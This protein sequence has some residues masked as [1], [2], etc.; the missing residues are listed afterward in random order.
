MSKQITICG[1]LHGKF[2]DL[3]VILHKNGLPSAENPYIFNGDFVD[4]GKRG[5]EVFLILLLCFIA[6]PGAVYLN[7]GN[8]EDIIMNQRYGFIREVQSKYKKN[9]EKLLKLIEGVYRYL[10]L[11]TIINNKVLVVH[12]GIS[13]STDLE[14][15]R[16]L[17]RGKYASLLRP[18][19][20]DSSAPG[21]EVINKVEWKQKL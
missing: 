10:P 3:L 4:R 16:S 7:R 5:L 21:S 11:G 18:P 6:I 8:H 20:S 13:D 2:D 15:I 12:G 14:M 19:L 1:D 17:D 9:H